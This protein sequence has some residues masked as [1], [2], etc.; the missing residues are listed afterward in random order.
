[1][2]ATVTASISSLILT[3]DD[4]GR[5][6]LDSVIVW[7]S[8]TSGF[9]PSSANVVYKGKS[10]SVT[11]ANLTP[12]TTYYLK[13][14]Y[15]SSI[16][17]DNY[18]ISSQLSGVPNKIDGS[19]IVDGLRGK[20]LS[21]GVV[22]DGGSTVTADVAKPTNVNT[23]TTVYLDDTTDFPPS[24][25]AVIL[26]KNGGIPTSSFASWSGVDRPI[27]LD[28]RKIRYTGKTSNS[29]TGVSG[30]QYKILTG[31]IVV[32]QPFPSFTMDYYVAGDPV[33]TSS[34]ANYLFRRSGGTA[35]AISQNRVANTFTYTA[36]HT[37]SGGTYTSVL[38]G[39]SGLAAF[40][41]A[42][43]SRATVIDLSATITTAVASTGLV[44]TLTINASTSFLRAGGGK[45]ILASTTVSGFK[46]VNYSAYSSTTITLDSA[47]Y[48]AAGTY[49]V[50]PLASYNVWGSDP[51]AVISFTNTYNGEWRQSQTSTDLKSADTLLDKLLLTPS[52]GYG[53]RIFPPSKAAD[54]D[55]SISGAAA[56]LVGKTSGSLHFEIEPIAASD[57]DTGAMYGSLS[58]AFHIGAVS[59]Y[60]GASTYVLTSYDGSNIYH[61]QPISTTL[62][63]SNYDAADVDS[64]SF[65]D[66]S[67]TF[68]FNADGGSGN[69]SI[70][71]G[72]ITAGTGSGTA[73]V[74]IEGGAGNARQ[75]MFR[76]AGSNRWRLVA[77]GTTESG[78]NAGSNFNITRYDDSAAAID[79]PFTIERA[80]GN[81]TTL[82][83]LNSAGMAPGIT[84]SASGTTVSPAATVKNIL[85]DRSSTLASL[86]VTLPLTNVVNGQEMRLITRSA[87]TALTV[88]VESAGTIYNAPTTLAAGASV[89]FVY[90]STAAAW[91]KG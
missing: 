64:I 63:F 50:I 57:I 79:N 51:Y 54:G 30:L 32:P 43:G 29:L 71:C 55:K 16:E 77:T 3:L 52:Y 8:T 49:Y 31:D 12:L 73:I 83:V 87:I 68:F 18:V 88:N 25:A 72:S 41:L 66:T 78:S 33:D 60:S 89:V 4:P 19:L 23:T 2:A 46:K 58:A 91:F 90:N 7:G 62:R 69:G 74:N 53:L 36:G 59:G 37:L 85:I 5:D 82:N 28:D 45:I 84:R 80:T 40:S 65:N 1:M 20:T 34:Y 61:Y 48:L 44:S 67:N 75:V 15:V 70:N 14:A 13:Y 11:I 21:S 24:G 56:M 35:I 81:I 6:D 42:Y 10:L 38:S 17:P 86:T 22:F 47:T 76:T 26:S 39:V 27:A 9:T